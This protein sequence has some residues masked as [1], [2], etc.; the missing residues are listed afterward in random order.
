M[1]KLRRRRLKPKVRLKVATEWMSTDEAT[2]YLRL[3]S[4]KNLYEYVRRGVLPA[5]RLGEKSL[6]FS[7][8][9]LDDHIRTQRVTPTRRK[10]KGKPS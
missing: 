2:E 5:Y 9:E 3:S 7:K 4:K 6:I 1:P 10:R 8:T